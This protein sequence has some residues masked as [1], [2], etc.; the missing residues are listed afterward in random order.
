MTPADALLCRD[1]GGGAEVVVLV[2]IGWPRGIRRRG[3]EPSTH[4]V[5]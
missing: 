3:R 4:R 2:A 5:A 1:G